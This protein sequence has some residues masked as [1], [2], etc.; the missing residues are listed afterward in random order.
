GDLGTATFNM[1]G[2]TFD[3]DSGRTSPIGDVDFIIGRHNTAT[4][5]QTGG[6]VNI[7]ATVRVGREAGSNGFLNVSA[8][9]LNAGTGLLISRTAGSGT[10]TVSGTGQ[11][12]TGNALGFGNSTG[13]NNEGFFTLTGPAGPNATLTV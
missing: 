8:G 4:M 1:S 3:L 9:Q 7:G 5:S 11:V 12:T 6:I 10:M 13:Y 2:G